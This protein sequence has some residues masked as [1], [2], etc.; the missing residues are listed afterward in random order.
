MV[1]QSS[2]NGSKTIPWFSNAKECNNRCG[3][4]NHIEDAANTRF[5]VAAFNFEFRFAAVN[6]K[7]TISATGNEISVLS[8]N[9]NG[10]K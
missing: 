10:W 9:S 7:T 8:Q 5:S 2:P 6:F 4:V 3:G 1:P